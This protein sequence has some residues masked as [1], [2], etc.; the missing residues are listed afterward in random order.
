[1]ILIIVVQYS[2]ILH[3]VPMCLRMDASSDRFCIKE[4]KDS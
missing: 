4:E 2:K 3:S 1:M